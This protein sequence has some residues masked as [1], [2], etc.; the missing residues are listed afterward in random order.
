MNWPLDNSVGTTTFSPAIE[1]AILGLPHMMIVTWI[2]R[3][4]SKGLQRTKG[5]ELSRTTSP[6]QK[7]SFKL[8]YIGLG[9][10]YIP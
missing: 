6:W 10:E 2:E 5:T 3:C 9:M 4:N 1:G 8:I 7:E